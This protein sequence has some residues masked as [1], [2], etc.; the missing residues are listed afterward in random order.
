MSTIDLRDI[1]SLTDFQRNAK[2]HITRLSRSGKAQV[3]T[4]NGKACLVVQDAE[5]YQKLLDQAE[6]GRNKT[7]SIVAG[8]VPAVPTP[9]PVVQPAASKPA[10]A[11][12]AKPDHAVKPDHTAKPDQASAIA[13]AMQE[14][15]RNFAGGTRGR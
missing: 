15:R 7:L 13:A 1:I 4:V 5:A 10:Q 3:L 11:L 14:L 6:A 9:A 8:S 12:E 2:Q